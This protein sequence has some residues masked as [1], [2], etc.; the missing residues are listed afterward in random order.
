MNTK[1]GHVQAR[2]ID[3]R[4]SLDMISLFGPLKCHSTPEQLSETDLTSLRSAIHDLPAESVSPPIE[5][6]IIVSFREG[7]NWVTRSYRF[8]LASG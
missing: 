1:A 6:L 8:D 4:A 3:V 7:T 5:R 2:S